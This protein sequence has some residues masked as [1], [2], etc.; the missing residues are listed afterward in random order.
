VQSKVTREQKPEL[1]LRL[2]YSDEDRPVAD[3][4]KQ[5][6]IKLH[7]ATY[8]ESVFLYDY[9]GWDAD[10]RDAE[11]GEYIVILVSRNSVESRW[12]RD[13][14]SQEQGKY[15]LMRGITLL[16]VLVDDTSL[17]GYLTQYQVFDLSHDFATGVGSLV[18][19]ISQVPKINFGLLNADEFE[20]LAVDLLDHLGFTIVEPESRL[21]A[22]E[23]RYD[24][25]ADY[26]SVD[27]FGGTRTERWLIE[28]RLY[29]TERADLKA[30]ERFL[31]NILATPGRY[32]AAIITNGQLTS[33][34][35][36]WLQLSNIQSQVPLR[37]IEGTDL[38]RLLLN[39]RDLVDKYFSR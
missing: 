30:L 2:M 28:L 29:K 16:P 32:H 15:L 39:Y 33:A 24:I 19:K 21:Q 27:P 14:F 20:R 5:A 22:S 31:I 12:L 13:L 10:E 23:A 6:L 11:A 38:K 25:V 26:L 36:D 7:P 34:T 8:S 17:P 9:L 1:Y 35:R 37:V 3:T 4:I 18:A